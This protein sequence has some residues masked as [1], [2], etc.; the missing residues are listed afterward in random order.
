MSKK[1]RAIYALVERVSNGREGALPLEYQAARPA[2]L[3]APESLISEPCFTPRPVPARSR[4]RRMSQCGWRRLRAGLHVGQRANPPEAFT[5]QRPPATPRISA[6]SATVAP[7]PPNPVDVLMK[8]APAWIAIS[9]PRSFSSMLS[10]AVSRI[11]LST[12]RDGERR[13]PLRERCGEP[14]GGCRS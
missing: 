4:P 14:R 8:S 10:S 9:A 13:L 6:T 3:S 12:R 1:P 7:P 2:C 5:P 11:T